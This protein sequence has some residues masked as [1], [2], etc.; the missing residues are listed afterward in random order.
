MIE[1]GKPVDEQLLT[2]LMGA[3]VKRT[4]RDLAIGAIV[5]FSVA[6]GLAVLGL[7]L[8]QRDDGALMP[9][10]GTAGLCGC[11]AAGL[12]AASA[13][14]RRTRAKDEHTRHRPHAS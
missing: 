6:V 1:S 8:S 14:V 3:E 9:L 2:K 10:L 5:V 13:Y 11:I 12:L 4:D 7:V